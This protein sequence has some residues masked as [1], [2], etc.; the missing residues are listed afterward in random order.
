MTTLKID[1]IDSDDDGPSLI[2]RG[3]KDPA[4]ILAA[5]QGEL[6]TGEIVTTT[7]DEIKVEWWR[8]NP[9]REGFNCDYQHTGHWTSTGARQS[10]GGFLAAQVF[11]AYE[12]A[13]P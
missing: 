10:R 4:E 12:D 1:R 3:L 7:L 2:V 6:D 13:Q 8:I 9:C 11:V 5:A